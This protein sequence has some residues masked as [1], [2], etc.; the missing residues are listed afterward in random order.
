MRFAELESSARYVVAGCMSG[1]LDIL[2]LNY[3][4]KSMNKI[5]GY[6]GYWINKRGQVFSTRSHSGHGNKK[7]IEL[8]PDV[9]R[10][11]QRVTFSIGGRTKRALVH[12][13]VAMT[14]LPQPAPEQ[15]VVRHLDGDPSNNNVWNLAWGT[16]KDNEADKRRHG[17]TLAGEKVHSAKLSTPQVGEIRNSLKSGVS[18]RDLMSKYG[19]SRSTITSINMNAS[20][21]DP[22]WTP[23]LDRS[24]ERASKARLTWGDVR[25]IRARLA[26]GDRNVD[27]AREF[28]VPSSSISFIKSGRTWKE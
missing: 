14:Y 24:G 22:A 26:S 3:V 13:L 18:Q 7:M 12:R 16:H 28:G 23:C 1:K 20:W 5:D 27:L 9:D 10:G 21:Y 11:Y 4:G 8:K 15:Q 17:R 2:M 6:D 25:T 19:V